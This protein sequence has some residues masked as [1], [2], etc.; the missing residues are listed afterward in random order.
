VSGALHSAKSVEWYTPH[1]IV[2]AARKLMGGIDC[3]PASSAAANELIRAR[4]FYTAVDD[5]LSKPW[6]GRV[7]LNPPGG[8]GVVKAFWSKLVD[9]WMLDEIE[10]AIFVGYSL[11][12]LQ[13]LQSC[14]LSPLDFDVCVPRK[15]LAFSSPDGRGG[16][17]THGNF[18]CWL[19]PNSAMDSVAWFHGG[20]DDIGACTR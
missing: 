16:S 2:E 5:G 10:Q 15:R 3:D 11:E 7:F 12:Q 8:R 18:I 6:F 9:H 17:P 13:T 4:T 19:P 1:Y 14:R 20:F